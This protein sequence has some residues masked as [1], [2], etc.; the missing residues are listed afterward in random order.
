MS[1]VL[2]SRSADFLPWL[3]YAVLILG[4][5]AALLLLVHARLPRR[6]V[7]AVAIATL[8]SMLAGPAAYA[9]D[10]A[11]TAA[12]R[13][14]PDRRSQHRAA[15]GMGRQGAG[16]GRPAG[17]RHGPAGAD[18]SGSGAR[19]PA[20]DPGGRPGGQTPGRQRRWAAVRLGVDRRDQRAAERRRRLVHLGR[21]SRRVELRLGL[22]ARD[23]PA[24]HGDRRVQRL[25]PEPDA[26]P[27]QA[28]RRRRE[29][30][31]LHRQRRRSGGGRGGA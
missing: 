20:A 11:S 23:R 8:I 19:R 21:C 4:G 12:H 15:R 24:R 29:D 28:V 6:A 30:P 7:L 18:R 9:V 5:A 13:L 1:F 27:V 17:R 3:K 10:T 26:R 22:P 16:G 2:L 25:R 31:L 14:H